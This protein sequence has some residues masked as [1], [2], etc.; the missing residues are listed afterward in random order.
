M[1]GC[2]YIYI[3]IYRYIHIH[4]RIHRHIHVCVYVSIHPSI[5][6]CM[7]ACMHAC[8]HACMH[9]CM[10]IY[11][12]ARMRTKHCLRKQ[13]RHP[14]LQD[15]AGP[16]RFESRSAAFGGGHGGQEPPNKAG[17]GVYLVRSKAQ[18]FGCAMSN[19]VFRVVGFFGIFRR[20]GCSS[21]VRNFVAYT[22]IG[23]Y[24]GSIKI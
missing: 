24:Q 22:L 8:I 10:H 21:F 19:L 4:K 20:L 14:S 6:P 9:A 1:C 7:H 2:I 15:L 12:C 23:S 13:L 11:R 18:G 5:H 16:H 3:C 17:D